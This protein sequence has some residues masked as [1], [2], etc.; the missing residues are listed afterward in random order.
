MTIFSVEFI[1]IHSFCNFLESLFDITPK[2]CLRCCEIS[3]DVSLSYLQ[4]SLFQKAYCNLVQLPYVTILLLCKQKV[5]ICRS[6]IL[7]YCSRSL[8]NEKKK[9]GLDMTCLD[10]F[11]ITTTRM[12]KMYLNLTI[13]KCY[14]HYSSCYFQ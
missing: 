4:N 9:Q 8:I 10:R 11:K 2:T 5:F 1:H 12:K 7:S 13:N 3:C 6:S 14:F